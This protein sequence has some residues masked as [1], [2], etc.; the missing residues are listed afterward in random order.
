MSS[1]KSQSKTTRVC[2]G[3]GRIGPLRFALV[4]KAF[5]DV[6]TKVLPMAPSR[7]S[8]IMLKNSG[9]AFGPLVR[10]YPP[11]TPNDITFGLLGSQAPRKHPHL[12]WGPPRHPPLAPKVSRAGPG[13]DT[14]GHFLTKKVEKTTLGFD[15]FGA[16]APH[17]RLQ[18]LRNTKVYKWN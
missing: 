5:R 8:M 7:I 10:G 2:K 16:G 6:G 13:P 11:P 9:F 12:G 17:R 18:K 1:L 14:T 15:F 3:I 4:F